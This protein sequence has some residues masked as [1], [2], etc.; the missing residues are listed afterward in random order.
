MGEQPPCHSAGQG[1]W[2]GLVRL[3]AD[4]CHGKGEHD[5]R[6]VAMPAVPGAGLVVIETELVLGRLK[7]VFNRPAMAFD[8]DQSCVGRSGRTPSGEKG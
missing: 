4:R 5:Q 7:T 3:M 1:F 2:G 8:P 6:D